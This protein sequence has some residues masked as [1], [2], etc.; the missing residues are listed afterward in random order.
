M[1]PKFGEPDYLRLS[2]YFAYQPALRDNFASESPGVER[3][4]LIISS[5]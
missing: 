2:A 1:N 4:S 5:R 3:K